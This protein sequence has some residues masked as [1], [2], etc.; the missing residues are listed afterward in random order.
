ML[1]PAR[2]CSQHLS[3]ANPPKHSE[4][5]MG[6]QGVES[7]DTTLGVSGRTPIPLLLDQNPKSQQRT[8]L[9][10]PQAQKSPEEKHTSTVTSHPQDGP[11]FFLNNELCLFKIKT[12]K[13]F[14]G[15]MWKLNV[16]TTGPPG[17]PQ[18]APHLGKN[19]VEMVSLPS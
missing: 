10:S 13:K 2:R 12:L 5:E 6:R 14:L 8:I 15:C 16:L 11:H 19:G 18:D 3:G 1:L 4:Q 17:K 7:V 9:G